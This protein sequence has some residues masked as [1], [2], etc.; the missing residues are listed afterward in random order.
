MKLAM[1]FV[2]VGVV[3]LTLGLALSPAPWTA[4]LVPGAALLAAGLIRD[5]DA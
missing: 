3:L 2:L 4:L 1:V 5:V